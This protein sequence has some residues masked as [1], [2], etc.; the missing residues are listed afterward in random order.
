MVLL[1]GITIKAT[2]VIIADAPFE[3]K[4]YF[5]RVP[6]LE[7]KQPEKVLTVLVEKRIKYT[8]PLVLTKVELYSH[9]IILK[10]NCAEIIKTII[11]KY[12]NMYSN[13]DT[14]SSVDA[15]KVGCSLYIE[16]SNKI[17]SLLIRFDEINDSMS[18][19]Y[20]GGNSGYIVELDEAQRKHLVDIESKK[21][22]GKK[23]MGSGL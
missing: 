21:F 2:P 8:F 6:G 15:S 11:K 4:A 14:V 5:E 19:E 16:D 1:M 18:M 3:L 22:K 12:A 23:D 13:G 9:S 20:S 17:S 10:D 7:L